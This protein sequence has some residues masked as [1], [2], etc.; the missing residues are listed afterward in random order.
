MHGRNGTMGRRAHRLY[1]RLRQARVVRSNNGR[2]AISGRL[3][4]CGEMSLGV[5]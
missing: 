4:R 2:M 1:V 3:Q 5:W